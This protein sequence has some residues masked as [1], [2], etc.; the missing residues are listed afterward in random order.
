MSLSDTGDVE[1][2]LVHAFVFFL[3]SKA[4]H[5]VMQPAPILKFYVHHTFL[6]CKTVTDVK[7]TWHAD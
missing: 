5:S 1:L 3:N 7:G 4:S 6:K 2:L